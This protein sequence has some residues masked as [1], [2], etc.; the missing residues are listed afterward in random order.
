MSATTFIITLFTVLF[1]ICAFNFSLFMTYITDT[2]V[3]KKNIKQFYL[4]AWFV[5]NLIMFTLLEYLF[6]SFYHLH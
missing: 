5:S 1:M 6:D 4:G 2:K 3:R